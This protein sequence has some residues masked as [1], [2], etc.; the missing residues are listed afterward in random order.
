MAKQKHKPPTDEA[1]A[2]LR[3]RE[4][5]KS[6][7][8]GVN[9]DTVTATIETLNACEIFAGRFQFVSVKCRGPMIVAQFAEAAEAI[10]PTIRDLM[11]F[12]SSQAILAEATGIVMRTPKRQTIK[13]LWEPTAQIILRLAGKDRVMNIHKLRDEFR[14]I[15]PTA[16]KLA[17]CPHAVNNEGEFLDLMQQCYT[18]VRDPKGPPPRCVI[19]HDGKNSYV[20]Q[21]SLMQWLSTPGGRNKHYDWGDVRNALLLLDFIP[22]Q[23]HRSVDNQNAKVRLWRG[24]LDLLV[25]DESGA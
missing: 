1:M 18:H 4:R 12:A 25:D 21:P 22:E 5:P 8:V 13:S 17:H 11:N 14:E 2:I 15:L 9:P 16:W 3:G 6:F 19:W 24:P 7:T 20:H 23:I 10:W